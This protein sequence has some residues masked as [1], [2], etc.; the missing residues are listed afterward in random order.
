MEVDRLLIYY[1]S[2]ALKTRPHHIIHYF[3]L[4]LHVFTSEKA[5]SRQFQKS[6]ILQVYIASYH[7][8]TG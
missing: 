1:L 8:T 3:P 4:G 6:I 5:F 7:H 2:P